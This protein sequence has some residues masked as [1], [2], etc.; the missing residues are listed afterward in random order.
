MEILSIVG[1]L[2]IS[3]LIGIFIRI[4]V[5][6]KPKTE[7]V[8]WAILMTFMAFFFIYSL[9]LVIKQETPL[10]TKH[11]IA[12]ECFVIS[13]ALFLVFGFLY[14]KNIKKSLNTKIN[15]EESSTRNNEG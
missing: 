13:S 4:F 1:I 7:V 6:K 3:I 2:L 14:Y 9:I 12:N 10:F 5:R 8:I 11:H 15:D